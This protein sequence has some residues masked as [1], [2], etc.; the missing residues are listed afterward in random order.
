MGD[1]LRKTK[2]YR[3]VLAMLIKIAKKQ[4]IR[5]D[6]SDF[7]DDEIEYMNQDV[8]VFRGKDCKLVDNLFCPVEHCLPGK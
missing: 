8:V 2:R 1:Q 7:S 6:V 3:G 5:F 4:G